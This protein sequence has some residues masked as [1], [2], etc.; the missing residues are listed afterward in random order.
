MITI[1]SKDLIHE[2]IKS[3]MGKQ[4]LRE[5]GTTESAFQQ[6]LKGLTLPI[7]TRE[8]K[9]LQKQ[10]KNNQENTNVSIIIL[11]VNGL[12]ALTKNTD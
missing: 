4:K 7:N 6:I 12:N 10:T 2:G 3:F 9:D 8:R 11:N 1:P 5:F